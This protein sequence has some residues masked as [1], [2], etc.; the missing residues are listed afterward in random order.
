MRVLFFFAA[1]AFA[2]FGM[3]GVTLSLLNLI[4]DSQTGG[5]PLWQTLPMAGIGAAGFL[6]CLVKV[7]R[8]LRAEPDETA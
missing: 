1:L 7:I 6:F 5:W 4:D 3:S 8:G 2:I